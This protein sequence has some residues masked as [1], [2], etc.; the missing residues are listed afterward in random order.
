MIT[1]RLTEITLPVDTES[2]N[3]VSGIQIQVSLIPLPSV[4][5]NRIL[6]VFL[7]C[8]TSHISHFPI[9]ISSEFSPLSG[10]T[11]SLLR[12]CEWESIVVT[13]E[14]GLI[15]FYFYLL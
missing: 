14:I 6:C 3:R 5:I 10:L 8:A 4:Q 13:V 11:C 2:I 12:Q 1:L 9:V 7:N 15:L